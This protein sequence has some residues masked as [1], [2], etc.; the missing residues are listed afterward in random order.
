[1][2][3]EENNRIECKTRPTEAI[4]DPSFNRRT[5]GVLLDEKL[6]TLKDNQGIITNC[7]NTRGN[8]GP[9]ID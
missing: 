4:N 7:G 9:S 5:I 3:R 1:M 8:N 6:R 2:A